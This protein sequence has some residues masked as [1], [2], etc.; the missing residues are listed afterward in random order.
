M[1]QSL[2]N[3]KTL[4]NKKYNGGTKSRTRTSMSVGPATKKSSNMVKQGYKSASKNSSFF[5]SQFKKFFNV[6]EDKTPPPL[7]INILN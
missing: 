4:K 5:K 3:Y 6:I 1:K 7:I 2:K